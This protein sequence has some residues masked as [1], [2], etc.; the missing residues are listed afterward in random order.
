MP[1]VFL[2]ERN[3]EVSLKS[4]GFISP[5]KRFM[6]FGEK[7]RPS[8]QLRAPRN[9]LCPPTRSP[10]AACP[11]PDTAGG[12]N[13]LAILLSADLSHHLSKQRQIPGQC[14]SWYLGHSLGLCDSQGCFGAVRM[15]TARRA[16]GIANVPQSGCE[17][18]RECVHVCVYA[19]MHV[20]VQLVCVC[21]GICVSHVCRCVSR[22]SSE[23]WQG[24]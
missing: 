15:L 16:N 13:Q 2:G 19:Q 5:S 6:S 14:E 24:V 9:A 17:G 4:R 3:P 21:N 11:I 18:S 10:E 23:D 7:G 1:V 8:Q 20:C 12:N 22:V